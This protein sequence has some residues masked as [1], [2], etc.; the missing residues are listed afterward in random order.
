M[1]NPGTIYKYTNLVN[2]KIYIGQT[3]TT[4][5]YRD[6]KHLS[7]LN[8]NTYFH[9]A[10]KKYGR[11]NFSLEIVEDN[12]SIEKLDDKEKYYI[13]MFD[14]FYTTGKG[15]NLTQGGKWGS[16]TQKLTI[17]QAIEIQNLILTSSL[18][19]KEIAKIYDI[20]IYAVS[21]I[22]RGVSFHNHALEYP[23]RESPKK[24]ELNQDKVDIIFDML[25]NSE[26]TQK[27]IALATDVNA[28]TVG[29][30]NQG[31]NSWCPKDINY[32]IRKPIQQSTYQNVLHKSDVVEICYKLCFSSMS[33]K[34]IGAEYNVASN[35]I[36]DISRGISWKEITSKF[37]CPIKK[38]KL[39]NQ[40]IYQSIYGIV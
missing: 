37:V 15:Y 14:S 33:F 28:Y 32:P 35:T 25:T 5:E 3:I 26:M 38:N 23:L 24:S 4:I 21:D 8:D 29:Q 22:N 12:I 19:L 30:L 16:G 7:Q 9:K 11:E 17:S 6:K 13:D 20:T 1:I 40:E 10:L 27:E 39:V 18:L 2:G 31:K 36:S 34:E